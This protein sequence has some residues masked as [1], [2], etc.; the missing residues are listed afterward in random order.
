MTMFVSFA[1]RDTQYFSSPRPAVLI[2]CFINCFYVKVYIHHLFIRPSLWIFFACPL[3][4]C[5]WSTVSVLIIVP[6]INLLRWCLVYQINYILSYFLLAGT[7]IV[8]RYY[9]S[10]YWSIWVVNATKS[11]LFHFPDI[12]TVAYQNKVRKGQPEQLADERKLK[13]PF[14]ITSL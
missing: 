7:N 10:I 5:R 2:K 6:N 11:E 9:V 12:T 8:C 1:R 3:V 14:K 13:L 4:L